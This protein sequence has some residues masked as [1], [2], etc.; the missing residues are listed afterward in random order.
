MACRLSSKLCIILQISAESHVVLAVVP[1]RQSIEADRWR[2]A[3]QGSTGVLE[4]CGQAELGV[5]HEQLCRGHGAGH[6]SPHFCKIHVLVILIYIN[7]KTSICPNTLVRRCLQA[8]VRGSGQRC[9]LL[10]TAM[11]TD[12]WAAYSTYSNIP[13]RMGPNAHRSHNSLK[14]LRASEVRQLGDTLHMP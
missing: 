5:Y 8:R 14:L 2:V 3:G 10:S 13:R 6:M 1:A 11:S 4:L 12:N 9:L 7:T